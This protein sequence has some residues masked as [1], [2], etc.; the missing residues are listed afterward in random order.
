MSATM[1]VAVG[2]AM[3]VAMSAGVAAAAAVVATTGDDLNILMIGYP[4]SQAQSWMLVKD[5]QLIKLE[6]LIVPLCCSSHGRDTMT[7]VGCHA[8]MHWEI[9]Q[10]FLKEIRSIEPRTNAII[11]LKTNAVRITYALYKYPT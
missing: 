2:V 11:L 8:F 7:L 5:T 1:G 4:F 9:K 3:G 10:L 6:E